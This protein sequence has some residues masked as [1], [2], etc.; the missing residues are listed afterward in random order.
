MDTALMQAP[1]LMEAPLASSETLQ[2][3][4]A[5]E[6]LFLE[7]EAPAGVYVI[8]RGEVNLLFSAR[9]GTVRTLR[10]ATPVQILG[11]SAVVMGRPHDCSATA[12]TCCEVGFI[13][14]DGFMRSME[15]SPSFR[16]GVLQM[17]SL[18][19]SSAYDDMRKGKKG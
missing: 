13:E 7:G 9:N 11:L 1:Q 19:V 8:H 12:R 2:H 17:L 5:G 16:F 4:S 15:D 3:R 6:M 10:I 14:R 18:D